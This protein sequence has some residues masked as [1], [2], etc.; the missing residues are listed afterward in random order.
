LRRGE[1]HA[2]GLVHRLEHAVDQCVEF[3]RIELGHRLARRLQHRV[4][5]RNLT[6]MFAVFIVGVAVL[7]FLE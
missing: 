4:S 3:G 1:S 2:L 7:L 5:S 6:R